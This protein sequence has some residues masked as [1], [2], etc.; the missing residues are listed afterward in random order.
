[1]IIAYFTF[2]FVTLFLAF[3]SE[4]DL[5]LIL[6]TFATAASDYHNTDFNKILKIQALLTNC[7]IGLAISP[8][9]RYVD[10]VS[11]ISLKTIHKMWYMHKKIK[12]H[13][14]KLK[15]KARSVTLDER[16]DSHLQHQV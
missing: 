14:H 7:S 4:R 3:S 12:E 15:G 13:V 16:K 5:F 1:M 10:F 8:K 9:Y 6:V 11:H 2:D